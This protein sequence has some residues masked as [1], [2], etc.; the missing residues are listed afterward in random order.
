MTYNI[1]ATGSDGNAVIINDHYLVDCGVPY[2]KLKPY[3]KDLR[4]VLLT[5]AHGDHFNKATIQRLAF[6]R[7]AL[8]FGGCQW[9]IRPLMDAGIDPIRIDLYKCGFW[10]AYPGFYLSPIHLTHNVE[11]CGYRLDDGHSRA[12]YATDTGTMDGIEAKNYDLYFLEANHRRADLEARIAE[13]QA[14]GEYAYE[15]GAAQNHL[16]YE[17]AIDWLAENMGPTSLWL[18]MHGHKDKEVTNDGRTP[19]AG[20]DDNRK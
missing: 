2:K 7:P 17:Q 8:R 16:S 3:V 6:D 5:H 9:M 18:P 10:T 19:D 11:N 4:L 1:I 12:L 14:A 20:A 15:I 13:K